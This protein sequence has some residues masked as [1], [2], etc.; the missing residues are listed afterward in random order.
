MF[1]GSGK[2][3][4]IYK[5]TTEMGFREFEDKAKKAEKT[6]KQMRAKMGCL[7]AF[8]NGEPTLLNISTPFLNALDD[9]QQ[10]AISRESLCWK[11][12]CRRGK[13]DFGSQNGCI[14]RQKGEH[15]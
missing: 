11:D 13:H 15:F 6:Q 7:Y 2:R 12:W 5:N 10:V 8:D 14:R 1:E 9:Q 3:L 4:L